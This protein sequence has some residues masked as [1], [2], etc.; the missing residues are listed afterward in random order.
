MFQRQ[1]G[2]PKEASRESLRGR[3]HNSRRTTLKRLKA[4]RDE[5]SIQGSWREKM[6]VALTVKSLREKFK[7]SPQGGGQKQDA[8][9]GEHVPYF[10]EG[11]DG[12]GQVFDDLDHKN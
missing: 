10:F 5:R 9:R 7:E 11:R 4:C 3:I 2:T 12:V 6:K 8:G 1:L